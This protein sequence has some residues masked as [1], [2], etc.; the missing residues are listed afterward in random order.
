MI[1]RIKLCF[2][3]SLKISG[4][5]TIE[6]APGMN[7]ITGPN[8][9]GKS[10]LLKALHD[11]PECRVEKTDDAETLYYDA[12]MMNPHRPEGPPGDLRTLILRARAG[13]SSHGEI[14]KTAIG[15]LPI[16]RDDTL[17]IDEPE[18][19]QDLAGVLRLEKGFRMLSRHNVQIIAASHHP[20]LL[21]NTHLIELKKGYA[22]S[23]L[24]QY[25]H[26]LCGGSG[27]VLHRKT[28]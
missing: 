14:L 16:R 18:T 12:E 26:R 11:C 15:S 13:F 24:R 4:L 25:R 22:E 7:V 23:L 27:S 21:L 20:L 3:H 6:F 17:L 10:T 2:N 9:S 5:K 8:G 1:S 28:K 19:G